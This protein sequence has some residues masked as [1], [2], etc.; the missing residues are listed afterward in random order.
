MPRPNESLHLVLRHQIV[1]LYLFEIY[2]TRS[3]C[4]AQTISGRAALQFDPV[5]SSCRDAIDT[6]SNRSQVVG[7]LKVGDLVSGGAGIL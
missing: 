6:D 1:R 4:H 7:T 5:S 2:C 3:N